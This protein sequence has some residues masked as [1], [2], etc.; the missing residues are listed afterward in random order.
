MPKRLVAAFALVAAATVAHAFPGGEDKKTEEPASCIAAGLWRT[1]AE[2]APLAYD[3]L[4]ADMAKRPVVLLGESHD[5]AEH[6]RWQLQMLSA[7]HAAQPNMVITFE[8]FPRRIQPVLDAWLR[9]DMD[10]ATFL[11]KSDWDTVWRFDPTLYLPLFH[12]ARMNRIPM[13][14]M[15]VEQSLVRKVRQEGWNAIDED[16]REG[17]GDPAPA[18]KSYEDRLFEIYGSHFEAMGKH[19]KKKDEDKEEETHK[20]SRDDADFKRFVQ[21]QTV[22]DRAMAE[23]I[24]GV[25]TGG[26]EPLVVGIVGSGHLRYR[27]GIPHQL[28]DL[29]IA[30]SAVLLP[31][32]RGLSC[33]DLTTADG[34]TVGDAVFGVAA[35]P[36]PPAPKR[37]LLGVRIQEGEG[38][39]QVA[40]VMKGS[41][42]EEAGI[43]DADLIIEA[44]GLKVAKTDE[45]IAI[46]RRQA[47][48]TWLPLKVERKGEVQEILAK[49]KPAPIE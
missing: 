5:N 14:A 21:A 35:P 42:A 49:F 10:E 48:G 15:N 8:M 18:A 9:G 43:E 38:G 27:Q 19:G 29:G 44:A 41:V 36:A 24:A 37:M 20:P 1:P 26:G 45:L 2:A 31:W 30:D 23:A 17:V 32:D 7:L 6:H 28:A 39:V 25:R 34:G 12:F 22:W 47:P 13:V 4:V 33:D 11:K 46:I 16:E 3:K 40:N